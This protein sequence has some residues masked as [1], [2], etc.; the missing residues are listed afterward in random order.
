M[1]DGGLLFMVRIVSFLLIVSVWSGLTLTRA[2]EPSPV[3]IVSGG[4]R[5]PRSVLV[6]GSG[7][8][9]VAEAGTGGDTVGTAD[10]EPPAGPITGGPTGQVSMI[11]DGCPV[12]A[13]GNLPSA[14]NGFGDVYGPGGITATGA[15]AFV[16]A[17]GG[18]EANGNPGSPTGVYEITTGTASLFV[19]LGAWFEANAPAQPGTG[20]V[21]GGS[22]WIGPV[23][24]PT[25]GDLIVAEQSTGLILSIDA[26]GKVQPLADFQDQESIPTA[27]LAEDDGSLLVAVSP[28]EETAP[29]QSA[30]FRVGPDGST[31]SIW[32]NLTTVSSIVRSGDGVL[33]ATQLSEVRD[34]PPFLTPGTGS[35]VRQ[36]GQ[37][38]ADVLI[39][40]LNF[41]GGLAIGAGGEIFAVLSSS[42]SDNGTGLIISIDLAGPFP[43]AGGTLNLASPSCTSNVSAI[44]IVVDDRGFNPSSISIAPGTTVTWRFGG[45]FDHAVVSDPA[46]Q[47]AFDSGIQ[48]PGGTFSVVFP[49]PGVYPYFDGM[50]P[51]HIA[52]IIVVEP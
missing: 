16:L 44:E 36:S 47:I 25:S 46:S 48:P 11:V 10:I 37:D 3:S 6:D 5:N 2:Q 49:D 15:R 35:I 52:E 13:I 34:R 22:S 20:R 24:N 30:V 28:V 33:L 18:G 45:E 26:A 31:E 14:R 9:I 41:P 40:Q 29:G 51:E 8:V 19:D 42:G 23:A 21:V 50:S 1:I 32:S 7:Q 12:V 39:D 4:L 27:L 17:S 38:S 43:I